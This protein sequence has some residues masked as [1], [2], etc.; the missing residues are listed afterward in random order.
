MSVRE[1]RQHPTNSVPKPHITDIKFAIN[2]LDA[3]IREAKAAAKKAGLDPESIILEDAIA[4]A[5]GCSTNSI[6]IADPESPAN[7]T[8]IARVNDEI[9]LLV[10]TSIFQNPHLEEIYNIEQTSLAAE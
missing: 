6:T 5:V 2:D 7:S 3:I 1:I 8:I 9:K 4:K 10:R